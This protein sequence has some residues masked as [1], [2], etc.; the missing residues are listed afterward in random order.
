VAHEGPREAK[1]VETKAGLVPS[2]D[3]WFVVNVSDS[4]GIASDQAGYAFLFEAAAAAGRTFPHFGINIHVLQPGQPA[5]LYHAEDTQ[6]AFLVLQG[7]C[8]LIVEDQER[9]LGQWDFFYSA[10]RTAHVIVGGGS[11]PCAVLMVG[12]RNTQ[13]VVYPVSEPAARYG[14]SVEQETTSPPDAYAGA[15]W[16]QPRPA[17]RPWPPTRR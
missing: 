12:A 15:G 17:R 1:L 2:D 10:P 11:G 8:L 7:E 5:S 13:D 14:A 6:E 4:A 3:G 9:R 16:E